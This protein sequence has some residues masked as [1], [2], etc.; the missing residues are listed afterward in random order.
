MKTKNVSCHTAI[1]K[2]VKQVVNAMVHSDNP[3]L[4]FP[5]EPNMF[6]S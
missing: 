2:P 4:V 5:A 6:N 1:S 3:P